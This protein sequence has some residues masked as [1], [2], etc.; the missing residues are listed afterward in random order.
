MLTLRDILINFTLFDILSR[1]NLIP[2]QVDIKAGKIRTQPS[3]LRFFMWKLVLGAF[4]LRILFAIVI[5][6]VLLVYSRDRSLIFDIPFLLVVSLGGI[7]TVYVL[8]SAFISLPGCT[9]NLA[10]STLEGYQ[11]HQSKTSKKTIQEVVAVWLP[12]NAFPISLVHA[13]KLVA[14]PQASYFLYTWLQTSWQTPLAFTLCIVMDMYLVM[15]ALSCLAFIGFFVILSFEKWEYQVKRGIQVVQIRR[16]TMFI[17][18]QKLLTALQT[19]RCL[20]LSVQLY[21][22]AFGNSMY[23]FKLASITVT[24][25]FISFSILAIHAS[26]FIL[27]AVMHLFLGIELIVAYVVILDKAFSVPGLIRQYKSKIL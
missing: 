3:K 17:P 13:C 19:C 7:I 24:V 18:A 6:P 20:V 10:N 23:L 9:E 11:R 5:L 15:Q 12:F 4:L 22:T 27:P 16:G 8:T 14:D 25:F 1:L 26:L 21:N 2:V